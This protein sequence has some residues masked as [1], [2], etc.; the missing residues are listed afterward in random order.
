MAECGGKR[1][2]AERIQRAEDQGELE[3]RSLA[4]LDQDEAFRSGSGNDTSKYRERREKRRGDS[5]WQSP[6]IPCEGVEPRV[7]PPDS[8]LAALRQP[9]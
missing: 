8:H 3:K 7:R 4:S 5:E 6:M 1:E 2:I 9:W